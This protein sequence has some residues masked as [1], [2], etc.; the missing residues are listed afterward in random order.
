MQEESKLR[1][2]RIHEVA[3]AD[4]LMHPGDFYIRDIPV[5]NSSKVIHGIIVKCP[6][7]G[8][9]MASTGGHR[10]ERPSR[11][12]KFFSLLGIPAGITIFP[13]L[14]CPYNHTHS[15]L[16]DSGRIHKCI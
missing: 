10:I 3:G 15:F 6:F 14:V 7:C 4:E 16:I 12:R 1:A 13:K 2:L 11:F 5:Y 9:D 8:G